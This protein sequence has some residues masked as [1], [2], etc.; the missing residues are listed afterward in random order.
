MKR[1][2]QYRK[3]KERAINTISYKKMQLQPK[4]AGIEKQSWW[5]ATNVYSKMVVQKTEVLYEY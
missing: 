5:Y 2:I 1:N 4:V 3:P